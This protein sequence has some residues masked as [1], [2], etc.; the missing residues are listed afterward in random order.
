LYRMLGFMNFSE[1]VAP[2]FTPENLV[3]EAPRM[4]PFSKNNK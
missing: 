3:D 4:Q 1:K 2:V